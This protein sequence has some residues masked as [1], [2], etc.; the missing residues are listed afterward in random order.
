MGLISWF[1]GLF[2]DE[3]ALRDC[4]D[5]GSDAVGWGFL[6]DPGPTRWMIECGDCDHRIDAATWD[7]ARDRWNALNPADAEGGSDGRCT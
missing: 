6:P 1:K 2:L 5:C 7:T 3:E 4:A